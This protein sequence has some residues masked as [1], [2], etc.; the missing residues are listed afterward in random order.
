MSSRS[1]PLAGMLLVVILGWTAR[2]SAAQTPAPPESLPPAADA[3][4]T[5]A[6]AKDEQPCDPPKADAP[7]KDA[8]KDPPTWHGYKMR[9]LPLAPPGGFPIPP[10]GPGYYTLLELVHGTPAEKPPRWPYPRSGPMQMSF[11]EID[12]SYLDAIPFD[13]RAWAEKLKRIPLGDHWLFST[14][15]EF[16]YRYNYET[17]SRLSGFNDTYN[18]YRNRTWADLWLE[19]WVRVYGEFY[20]GDVTGNDLPPYPRDVN[21]GAAQQLFV[22]VKAYE[23]DNHP[24]YVRLGRQELLY[25]SQRLVSPNDWGDNRARFDG[26]KAFYRSEKW[27]VDAFFTA[28]VLVEPSSPDPT[29]RNRLFSGFWATY[30]PKK[31]TFID[32]Y[33]LNLD[34]TTPGAA[35]GQNKTGA[36]SLNTVG[37]R[38]VG[39]ADN[40]FL[41]D[42]EGAFQFGGWADQ[43]VLA[44]MFS[45][46]VGWNWKDVWANPTVWFGYDYASG[47]PDPNKT[48]QHRTFNQLFAF[49]HY[50]LG[51]VDFVARQ[52]IHDFTVQTYAYPMK[53]LTTGLQ[54]HVFRLD[55]NKDALYPGTPGGLNPRQYPF[56]LPRRDP[57]GLAG[58][59]VG[60]EID[61]IFNAHLTDRQDIFITYS[62]FFPGRFVQQTGPAFPSDYLYAQYTW[63][64]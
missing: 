61:V 63:R 48:G 29:D 32:A 55:S 36:F 43:H 5:P 18:L 45:T 24:I 7:K 3:P 13:Q 60:S 54:Y 37:G 31:G 51:F 20:Y 57:T 15:G 25:G 26:V 47:D 12:F 52:N 22:D 40:G 34:N 44:Q 27:D 58:D 16:R 39:R 21:R 28:P 17:N 11:S 53:W 8:P 4:A 23:I 42:L 6:P 38:Y 2:M 50:Y 9:V 35:V 41:W 62:H 1:R 10:T 30:K 59:D 14:G 64:W 56:A 49:G 46:Y 19:D 33:Y